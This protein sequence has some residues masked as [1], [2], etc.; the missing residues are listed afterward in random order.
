M[1]LFARICECRMTCG[2]RISKFQEGLRRR[3]RVPDSRYTAE[4]WI[5]LDTN[6][7]ILEAE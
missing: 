1:G 6:A 5:T 4:G 2:L 3:D 7:A